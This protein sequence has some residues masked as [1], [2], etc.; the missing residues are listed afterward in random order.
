[1]A[2]RDTLIDCIKAVNKNISVNTLNGIYNCGSHIYLSHGN[3]VAADFC[4]QRMCPMCQWRLSRMAFGKMAK[5]FDSIKNDYKFIFVTYTI[6]N[7]YDITQGIDTIVKAH[8]K[9]LDR[10]TL[11]S[12]IRGSVR[13][14]EV[15]YNADTK[16]W[17]PHLH[18]L[19]AVDNDYFTN[20][21]KYKTTKDWV[22]IW[23]SV[24]KLDYDPVCY[25]ESVTGLKAVSEVA[26][27]VYKPI[28]A[29]ADIDIYKTLY[30]HL[31]K[32]RLRSYTGVL[33]QYAKIID[34]TDICSDDVNTDTTT[35][36][37]LLFKNGKYIISKSRAD[38]IKT[39]KKMDKKE[40]GTKY[41][42]S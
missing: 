2:L 5:I 6:R 30:K 19:Y 32:R 16:Q 31:Y 40:K 24:C 33:K 25:T 26:K 23:R 22:S 42:A 34:N 7:V 21:Q 8:K 15:T 14:I 39:A 20:P 13:T 12:V 10:R 28:S 17:H 3:I 35:T 29:A 9:M 41:K 37:Y 38:F 18:C 11:K 1:M 4:K 36:D 27:Y